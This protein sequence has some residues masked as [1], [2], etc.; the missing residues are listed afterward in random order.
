MDDASSYFELPKQ[1]VQMCG[2]V[3][4]DMGG[5]SRG[6]ASKTLWYFLNEICIVTHLL[7]SCGKDSLRK[8]YRK[9]DGEKYRIGNV[10]SH[11]EEVDET[12]GH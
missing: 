12:C 4:R 9:W 6:R 3:F 2:H 8:F 1:N 10:C 5:Q 11:V 7:G